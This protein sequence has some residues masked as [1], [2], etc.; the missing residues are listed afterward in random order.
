[1]ASQQASWRRRAKGW[2]LRLG[3]ISRGAR[4]SQGP[5]PEPTSPWFSAPLP[6]P[7]PKTLG[8]R[9]CVHGPSPSLSPHFPGRAHGERLTLHCKP[10]NSPSL[11][12]TFLPKPLIPCSAA[13][14]HLRL[15]PSRL[16]K[17]QMARVTLSPTCHSLHPD[18]HVDTVSFLSLIPLFKACQLTSWMILQSSPRHPHS[19]LHCL[20]IGLSY[21]SLVL[22]SPPI[23]LQPAV[24]LKCQSD[25]VTPCFRCTCTF[26]APLPGCRP[27]SLS[28]HIS[29]GNHAVPPFCL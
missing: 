4:S 22:S 24:L 29:C 7:D 16:C 14:R 13:S 5:G 3:R 9:G 23:T 20:H 6:P 26:R 2:D 27:G 21:F 28:H 19:W 12:L 18:T 25:R 15:E 11:A 1:M 17:P 8:S 10:F